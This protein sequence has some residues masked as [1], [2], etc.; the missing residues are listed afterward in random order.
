MLVALFT[1]LLLLK[2]FV[3]AQSDDTYDLRPPDIDHDYRFPWDKGVDQAQLHYI[4]VYMPPGYMN[5]YQGLTPPEPPPPPPKDRPER[6]Q[7]LGIPFLPGPEALM[8]A[9]GAAVMQKAIAASVPLVP[10]VMG[11]LFDLNKLFG[12]RN[13]R[14]PFMKSRSGKDLTY[15]QLPVQV[16]PKIPISDKYINSGEVYMSD[17]AENLTEPV[18]FVNSDF[19]G[20]PTPLDWRPPFLRNSQP[21]TDQP[22]NESKLLIVAEDPDEVKKQQTNT[23]VRKLRKARK[24]LPN[25]SNDSSTQYEGVIIADEN[26]D[27]QFSA[28]MNTSNSFSGWQSLPSSAQSGNFGLQFSAP[29]DGL[30]LSSNAPAVFVSPNG[31]SP[32]VIPYSPYPAVQWAQENQVPKQEFLNLPINNA[33]VSFWHPPPPVV[34]FSDD[35]PFKPSPQIDENWV[36]EVIKTITTALPAISTMKPE[37]PTPETQSEISESEENESNESNN[38]S[39]ELLTDEVK[40]SSSAQN[41]SDE[42]DRRLNFRRPK[43]SWKESYWRYMQWKA[44]LRKFPG[45]P[46]E[47][48]QMS[49]NL[50]SESKRS[51]GFPYKYQS[52]LNAEPNLPTPLKLIQQQKDAHPTLKSTKGLSE[53]VKPSSEPLLKIRVTR[54][55]RPVKFVVM[56]GNTKATKPKFVIDINGKKYPIT[57]TTK[58]VDYVKHHS[59]PIPTKQTLNKANGENLSDGYK[60]PDNHQLPTQTIYYNNHHDVDQGQ[61]MNSI[62]D[63]NNNKNHQYVKQVVT[64][65]QQPKLLKPTPKQTSTRGKPSSIQYTT[66]NN[67]LIPNGSGGEQQHLREVQSNYDHLGNFIDSSIIDQPQSIPQKVIFNDV[68]QHLKLQTHPSTHSRPLPSTQFTVNALPIRF[69]SPFDAPKM[70]IQEDHVAGVVHN[71]GRIQAVKLM[72]EINPFNYRQVLDLDGT[73]GVN[74]LEQMKKFKMEDILSQQK[75]MGNPSNFVMDSVTKGKPFKLMKIRVGR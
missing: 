61:N 20:I 63:S 75:A 4:P 32:Q 71:G 54:T 50:Q 41:E 59:P 66:S 68:Q 14:I 45:E 11:S 5:S 74:P 19:V 28:Q 27:K 70:M 64:Y 38:L 42:D 23:K 37:N 31:L 3:P 30:T 12:F 57:Q 22:V 44:K 24:R 39:P 8:A 2:K 6:K 25:Q 26:Y 16:I 69:S 51:P 40:L 56:P 48:G 55:S 65:R 15:G 73:N 46:T 21:V 13:R 35:K 67:K 52:S 36:P 17:R 58:S 18:K 49:D 47:N 7:F 72:K 53:Y 60:F 43:G 1:C 33:Q 10:T 9:S 29:A 34:G 62:N